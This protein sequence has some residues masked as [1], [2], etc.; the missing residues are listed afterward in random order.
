[1]RARETQAP[2][3]IHAA[4]RAQQIGEVMLAVAIRVHR[5]SEQDDFRHPL[6]HN[7]VRFAH[8]FGELTAP[9]GTARRWHDAVRAPIVAAALHRDPRLYLVEAARLEI[10]I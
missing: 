1:M 2:D 9:L 8:D 5:L 3:S 6:G 7:A 10:L 4:D